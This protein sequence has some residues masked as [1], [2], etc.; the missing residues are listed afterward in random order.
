MCVYHINL[1]E[2]LANIPKSSNNKIVS[3]IV[4]IG[5]A[6]STILLKFDYE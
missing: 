6:Y 5:I 1:D 3:E 2:V 4:F